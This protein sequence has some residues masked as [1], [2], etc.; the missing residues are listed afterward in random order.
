MNETIRKNKTANRLLIVGIITMA[1]SF[2]LLG[3]FT[4]SLVNQIIKDN[5]SSAIGLVL[6]IIFYLMPGIIVSILSFLFNA[7]AYKKCE[8]PKPNIYKISFVLSIVLPVIYF[9]EF[10]M[11]YII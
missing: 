9:I 7:L 6:T 5:F 1:I 11:L 2:I 4:Y 10:I 3:L 8:N